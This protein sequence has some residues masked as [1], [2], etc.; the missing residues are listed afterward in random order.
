MFDAV[1][2]RWTDGE[3]LSKRLVPR[4]AR[5]F[6]AS[7]P[8]NMSMRCPHQRPGGDAGSRHVYVAGVGRNRGACGRRRRAG[9]SI[10]R[11]TGKTRLR[12]RASAGPSRRARPRDGILP[13]QQRRGRRGAR[14]S[15]AA[16]RASPSSTS[17][18]TTA[19]ARSGSSTTIRGAVRLD[20]PIPVLPGHRRRDEIGTG[21]GR[22]FTVNVPL[23]VGATDADYALVYRA[24]VM[25]VLRHSRRS[26]SWSRP[27]ST[28]TSAIR[29][30]SMRVTTDG[31]ASVVRQSSTRR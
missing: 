31:Y 20:A 12:A 7:T 26:L 14:A 28:H 9:A 19:T 25:P 18:C 10:T 23:E 1:A 2:A 17:T 29:S 24:V 6:F 11:S 5:N 21:D 13:V 8:P 22:G 3:G 30:A 27:A 15:R 16:S 4:H